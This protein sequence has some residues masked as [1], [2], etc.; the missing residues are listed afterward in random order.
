MIVY[1]MALSTNDSTFNRPRVIYSKQLFYFKQNAEKALPEWTKT[2]VEETKNDLLS[3]VDS[4]ISSK[5][6]EFVLDIN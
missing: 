2:I 6:V 3:L 5:I 1:G 4:E